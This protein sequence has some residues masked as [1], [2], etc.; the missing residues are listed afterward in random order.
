VLE[1]QRP[2]RAA[3]TLEA[4]FALA[5]APRARAR[6]GRGRRRDQP[7]GERQQVQREQQP[8]YGRSSCTMIWMI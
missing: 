2:H 4:G 1:E 5:Q 6:E 7:G 8:R 3:V